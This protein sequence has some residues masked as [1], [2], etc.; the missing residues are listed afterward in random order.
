MGGAIEF[1]CLAADCNFLP[2][3]HP[4]TIKLLIFTI[5]RERDQECKQWREGYLL[6]NP[7]LPPW[8]PPL[9]WLVPLQWQ[10]DGDQDDCNNCHPPQVGIVPPADVVIVLVVGAGKG[11]QARMQAIV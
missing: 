4:P 9:P 5:E 10:W 1:N 2:T 3:P 6:L 8:S 11:A 7:S